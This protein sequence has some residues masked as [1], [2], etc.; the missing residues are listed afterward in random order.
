M[1]NQKKIFQKLEKIFELTF[2]QSPEK[3]QWFFAPGRVNLIGEHIDYC[4]GFVLPAALQ[5]GTYAVA[6]K[7]ASSE[8][9]MESTLMDNR[10]SFPTNAPVFLKSDGWGNY[11][12]GV[13]AEYLNRGVLSQGL[14]ILFHGDLPGGGLSSSASIEVC[15]AL[16]IETFNQFHLSSEDL[17]NRKKIAWLCQHSENHFNGINCGVMDQGAVALG[18]KD[19]ALLMDCRNLAIE[20]IP[21]DL[22][23]YSLLIGNTCKARKLTDSKYNERRAEVERALAIIQKHQSVENLCEIKI[24]D[25]E[26]TL[27]LLDDPILI[28]RTR[29]IISENNRVHEAVDSLKKG[30]LTL[31]GQKLIASHQSLKNDYEVTGK[32]LDTLVET[33][34]SQPGV[35]GARMTGGGFGG[36]MIALVHQTQVEA[37]KKNVTEIYETQIGYPPE[38]YQTIAGPGAGEIQR[39]SD[40]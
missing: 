37:F 26:N 23:E 7:T 18:K 6:R 22:G 38:F 40:E 1:E 17:Q 20:Y 35:L 28:K 34:L 8:I 2:G 9:V 25:L 19:H 31:F 10:V 4:G 13:F 36:C 14:E 24:S 12:K 27:N 33:G 32:E 5:M 39:L 3:R 11:P 16:M 30:R 21:I 15:A 29:H